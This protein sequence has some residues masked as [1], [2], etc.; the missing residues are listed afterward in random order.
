MKHKVIVS[1]LE[2][3]VVEVEAESLDG[4]K[5]LVLKSPDK[6]IPEHGDYERQ[7]TVDDYTDDEEKN[8]S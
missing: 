8:E 2:T 6:Y 4:A 7:I 5:E 1:W 3:A